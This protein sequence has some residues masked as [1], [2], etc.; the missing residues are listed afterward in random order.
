MRVAVRMRMPGMT[1]AV[2]VGMA[3]IRRGDVIVVMGFARL[4]MLSVGM[5]MA[6]VMGTVMA[7]GTVMPMTIAAVDD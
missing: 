3:L 6:M 2:R 4:A 1:R 7:M 5:A